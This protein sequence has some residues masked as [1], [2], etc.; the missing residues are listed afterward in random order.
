VTKFH[1]RG[2]NTHWHDGRPAGFGMPL[3][4]DRSLAWST[5]FALAV[6]TCAILYFA[7]QLLRG[8]H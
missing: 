5:R 8:W 4:V 1:Q 2:R 3:A 7:V 6:A